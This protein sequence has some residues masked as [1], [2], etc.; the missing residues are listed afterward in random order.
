ML[1]KVDPTW[2][3]H[4]TWDFENRLTSVQ[5][6]GSGGTV[7]FKCDPFGRRAEKVS[8]STTSIYIYDGDNLIEETNAAGTA[9]ARYT[10]GL[11][12][13]EPLAMLRGTTT[14]FYET[15]GLGSVT[16]LTNTSGANAQTY[17]YDS[18]GNLTASTGSLTNSFRYTAREFDSEPNLYF[19][20]ARY[21]DPNSG[22]FL[23]EDPLGFMGGLN[24]YSFVRNSPLNWVDRFGTTGS[25]CGC[26]EPN[27][28]RMSLGRR[29]GLVG[30]GALHLAVGSA[31]IGLAV[32]AEAETVGLATPVAGYLAVQGTGNFV[33]GMT[34]LLVGVVGDSAGQG[35]VNDVTGATTVLTSISG[36]LVATTTHDMELAGVAKSSESLLLG[37]VLDPGNIVN[38][39]ME[40]V[41]AIHE[42]LGLDGILPKKCS[43]HPR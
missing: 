42:V 22:K 9:V 6:P 28:N 17:T 20:R 10:Q 1:A 14:D 12:I 25:S 39:S 29:I 3:T 8:S 4:Y 13:D 43:G 21:Y 30:F 5:L 18:F 2:T 26:A 40:G 36:L 35:L 38:V 27:G 19:Y 31:K 33:Q 37:G 23:N 7:T 41:D 16:S 32:T 11:N 34:E 15:D 24:K